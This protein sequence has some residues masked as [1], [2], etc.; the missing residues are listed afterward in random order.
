LRKDEPMSKKTFLAC[1]IAAAVIMAML[2]D[3]NVAQS[4]SEPGGT[5]NIGVVS[6]KRVF[7]ESKKYTS[8]EEEMT[9]EQEQVLAQLEKARADIELE[10]AGLKTLKPGSTEYMGQVKVLIEKQAKLNAEQEFQK[11]RLAL[12]N[13]QWIEQMHSDIMRVAGEIAK[14]RGLDLVLQNSEVDL[15]EVP[16]D[17]LVLSILA[18]T[19]MYA[20]GC[21]DI[22]DEVIAQLD[23]GK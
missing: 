16:D 23:A 20:G 6:V 5:V 11:Q 10:R 2:F 3:D 8:F 18:R 19:V 22:T 9:S 4:K 17:M 21:V 12:R 15:A 1:C 7:D 14:S 13:R